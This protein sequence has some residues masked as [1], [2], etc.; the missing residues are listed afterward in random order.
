MIIIVMIIVIALEGAV[1]DFYCLLTASWTVSN[2]YTQ[3]AR[4]L[5]FANHVQH[6]QH[7]VCHVVERDISSIK[8]DRVE[9][10]YVLA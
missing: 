2:T 1:Q 10:T 9:I 6:M 8:F 4:A 5:S 3:V 7:V